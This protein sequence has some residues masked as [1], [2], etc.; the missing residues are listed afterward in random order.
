MFNKT[1]PFEYRNR[2]LVIPA[3]NFNK[4]IPIGEQI[5][6]GLKDGWFVESFS[7]IKRFSTRKEKELATEVNMTYTQSGRRN[8]NSVP[9]I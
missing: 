9:A 4:L 8:A 6:I 3:D 5:E 1:L 7:S 2:T